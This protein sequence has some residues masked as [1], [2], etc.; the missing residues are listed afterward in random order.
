VD[1]TAVTPERAVPTSV[2]DGP[3]TTP[4]PP[5]A[6]ERCASCGS[7]LAPDQRYCLSCGERR[8]EPRLPVMT[9]RPPLEPP[10]PP[11]PAA[12]SP[13]GSSG[14]TLIAGV[15]TLVLALGVGVLIGQSGDTSNGSAKSPPFQ[16]VTVAGGGAVAGASSATPAAAAA[17]GAGA[18]KGAGSTAAAAK[19]KG[20]GSSSS[21]A[22]KGKA[23]AEPKAVKVGDKGSGKGYTDG[24]FTGDF[25]GN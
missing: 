14:A 6:A 5:P 1:S 8:G 20:S 2:G 19:G 12:R 13:R 11:R 7:R 23:T 3:P 15:G 17:A 4:L 24:K 9:G 10:A 18:A 22:A 16:V 21:S 25:F